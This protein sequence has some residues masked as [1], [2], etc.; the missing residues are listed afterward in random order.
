[1][2]KA[3]KLGL[4]HRGSTHNSRVRDT[5]FA[6]LCLVHFF[7]VAESSPPSLIFHLCLLFLSP[8][9][10]FTCVCVSGRGGDRN[11]SSV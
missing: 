10:V 6:V 7:L 1:M 2:G 3:P 4:L 9:R 11:L 8:R 5:K